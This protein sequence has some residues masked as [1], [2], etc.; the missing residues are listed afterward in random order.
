MVKDKHRIK[1][2][3]AVFCVLSL[4]ISA[5]IPGISAVAENA[6]SVTLIVQLAQRGAVK[7]NGRIISSSGAAKQ[8]VRSILQAQKSVQKQIARINPRARVGYSY[9]R[10]LNGFSLKARIS[11][12]EKIRSLNGVKAVYVSQNHTREDPETITSPE[13]GVE[14]SSVMTQVDL[15]Q[16]QG[17]RGEGMLIAIVDT[18]FDLGNAFLS[19]EPD[20]ASLLRYS[21]P[22]DVQSIMDNTEFNAGVSATRA[23]KNTKVPFAWDYDYQTNDT[24]NGNPE[25]IHGSHVAGIAAGKNGL[26]FDG[27][28]FNGVAPEAQLL[29]MACP[30]LSTESTIAAI[31]DAIKLGADSLNMSWGVDYVEFD[32]YDEI[33]DAAAASGMMLY[34]AAGNSSRSL[35][36]PETIDYGSTG[37]PGSSDTCMSVASAVNN[38]YFDKSCTI[39]SEG[40]FCSGSDQNPA[41]PFVFE[42]DTPIVYCGEYN[43]DN[44]DIEGKIAVFDRG[45]YT[46]GERIS[47]AYESGAVGVIFLLN[48]FDDM[49]AIQIADESLIEELP[50]AIVDPLFGD[51]LMTAE[52]ITA[53]SS[54]EEVVSDYNVISDF[55]SWG[56][57]KDLLLEPDITT[58]GE[59]IWS[60]VPIEESPEG[61][62]YFSGTSM[63]SP[64]MTG[65]SVLLKQYLLANEAGFA[66]KSA[67]EQIAEINERMMSAALILNEIDEDTDPEEDV[68]LPYSPRVQGAGLL[69]LDAAAKTP[70]VLEGDKGR[71]K[72]SL[73][74]IEDSFT[75]KFSAKNLSDTDAVYDG[76]EL[77]LFTETVTEDEDYYYFESIP[78]ANDAQGLPES[79]T[80]AAG[81]E[82]K[83]SVTLTPDAETLA[84]I[85]EMFTNGFFIDG[86]IRFTDSAET[87]PEISIPFT[88]FYGDWSAAPIFDGTYWDDDALLGFTRLTSEF[89][90]SYDWVNYENYLDIDTPV[91]GENTDALWAAEDAGY[92]EEESDI[93]EEPEEVGEDEE[94]EDDIEEIEIDLFGNVFYVGYDEEKVYSSPDYAAISPNFDSCYDTLMVD[95]FPLRSA[96]VVTLRVTNADGTDITEILPDNELAWRCISDE[97]ETVTPYGETLSID[98]LSAN[99]LRLISDIG[100]RPYDGDQ[101][102]EDRE[103]EDYYSAENTVLPDGEYT[104][105]VTAK[106]TEDS[107]KE[108]TLTFPFRV[109]TVYPEIDLISFRE[110]DGAV[111]LDVAASDDNNLYSISVNYGIVSDEE[112]EE[113]AP[114]EESDFLYLDDLF[115]DNQRNFIYPIAAEPNASYSFELTDFDPAEPVNINVQDYAGNTVLMYALPYSVKSGDSDELQWNKIECEDLSLTFAGPEG[116][117]PVTPSYVSIDQDLFFYLTPD[118]FTEDGIV[119]PAT[120]LRNAAVGEHTL[121]IYD[122]DGNGFS[123]I[124][125]V[126][127]EPTYEELTTE[128]LTAEP[129]T[130]EP[131]TA[132]PTT[133]EP[134]TAEPTTAEPTTA[135]PTTAEPTTAEPTTAEPTTQNT[136]FY[137]IADAN[138][139]GKI[140][141]VDARLTLRAAARTEWFSD[142]QALLA[143]IN[144]DKKVTAA[145]ARIILRIAANLEPKPD[146]KLAV[147]YSAE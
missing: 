12:I 32:L 128:S 71:S 66:E 105:T 114:E 7:K 6:Q 130:E 30:S 45:E 134:T 69:Q 60:S 111:I 91:L 73:R 61:Y 55:S 97:V 132:E 138:M 29:C 142:L 109:D 5:A 123:A 14:N 23:W 54:V 70:V 58:P 44:L 88:G 102:Y 72:I 78:L 115:G 37:T 42:E 106:F 85:A 17:F 129:T 21:S 93:P 41:S 124:L 87:I 26:S 74:T 121:W 144:G 125:T 104:L 9:T 112:S 52:W 99:V 84:E 95:L 80:V 145:D 137:N 8:S 108:E 98:R 35:L 63:A 16:Q 116:S 120:F 47:L 15:L 22:A 131:T 96:D 49:Y 79:L 135:E 113:E 53:E 36:T 65:A 46:F 62:T 68:I 64:H 59:M 136:V 31:D 92:D 147:Q 76:V 117:S 94:P 122:T 83:L 119:L 103:L 56:V 51:F 110:E 10:A 126:M 127:E 33:F 1:G 118:C 19:T 3:L 140:N 67:D 100:F 107:E 50:T 75:L 143:D 146:R 48:L 89:I 11:D 90:F 2:I 141:S 34:C 27:N 139:D 24:Y 28:A 38:D 77:I 40:L 82:E 86:F 39:R 101:E 18:E 81:S 4:L 13:V 20:D 133:A 57:G 43:T 25:M